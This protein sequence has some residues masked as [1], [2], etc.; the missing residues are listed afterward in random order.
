MKSRLIMKKKIALM[1]WHHVTNYGTALQAYALKHTIEKLGYSVDLI[2]YRRNYIAAPIK[3]S[4]LGEVKRVISEIEGFRRR[5]QYSPYN[6]PEELFSGFY[7]EMFTYTKTCKYNQDFDELLNEYNGFVC[8]SDQIWGPQWF[9]RRFFLDFVPE[10]DRRVAYAPSFG[11]S[12]ID[13]IETAQSMGRLIDGFLHVSSREKTGCEIIKKISQHQ[14]P[15]NVVDPVLLLSEGDWSAL[16]SEEKPKGKYSLLF[17]L[18][19]KKENINIA[20]KDASEK[21]YPVKICHCTQ[22]DDTLYA[23][24]E[25][26]TPADFL[27]L[28]QNAEY[29]YT[30]SF[31]VMLFSLIFRK[32]FRVFLK[33]VGDVNGKGSRIIDLLQELGLSTLIGNFE[34]D[35]IVDYDRVTSKIVKMREQSLEYLKKALDDV[36]I[37]ISKRASTLIDKKCTGEC[38]RSSVAFDNRLSSVRRVR[39]KKLFVRMLKWGFTLDNECYGCKFVENCSSL[40]NREKPAFYDELQDKLK[41]EN[42]SASEI[43]NE[44]C[45]VYV[46]F[47][48]IRKI[49]G[50]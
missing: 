9:D 1:T 10:P 8:G 2:D 49:L 21:S 30:D 26:G 41:D 19:N 44:Y 28:I 15:V 46:F 3:R 47:Q 13:N 48:K 34:G 29:I 11:V 4:Y 12:Q 35:A 24:I 6:I 18:K 20:L 27:S 50:R 14:A 7:N 37:M 23:N 32:Q 25:F 33:D 43:F 38:P 42:C 22:S 5:P 39:E 16:A 45:G 17:F 31:H 36:P 40:Y